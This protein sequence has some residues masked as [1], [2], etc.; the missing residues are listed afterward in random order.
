MAESGKRYHDGDLGA[1]RGALVLGA[2]V[3]ALGSAARPTRLAAVDRPA[4]AASE[5][6]G[7]AGCVEGALRTMD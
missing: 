5:P 3:A 2:V 6:G 1:A 4:S 7:V